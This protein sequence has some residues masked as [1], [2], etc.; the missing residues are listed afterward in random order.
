M[1][2]DERNK[3]FIR[4]PYAINE[5]KIQKNEF[6]LEKGVN[7]QKVFINHKDREN[8]FKQRSVN[9]LATS[10]PDNH[11]LSK[12]NNSNKLL[13]FHSIGS[14]GINRFSD[15]ETILFSFILALI[16]LNG[17]IFQVIIHWSFRSTQYDLWREHISIQ[18]KIRQMEK[19]ERNN[20]KFSFLYF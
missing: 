7:A 3:K 6:I 5:K 15:R 1:N 16:Y 12:F 20:N 13:I 17:N 14:L 19:E 9:M 18:T 4:M 2:R 10:V 8:S 11:T